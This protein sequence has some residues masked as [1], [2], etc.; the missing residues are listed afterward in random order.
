MRCPAAKYASAPSRSSSGSEWCPSRDTSTCTWT[1]IATTLATSIISASV[2][3]QDHHRNIT[4]GAL[5]ILIVIGPGCGH[6]LP[7]LGF[8]LGRRGPSMRLEAI[9]FDLDL[10]LGI[11][12]EVQVPG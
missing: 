3:G 8:L 11:G 5:L 1:S 6:R 7:Q 10:H 2:A 4:V 9:A 12:G